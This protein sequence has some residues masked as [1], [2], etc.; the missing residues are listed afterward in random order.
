ME[1]SNLDTNKKTVLCKIMHDNQSDKGS[2]IED[3]FSNKHNY[4]ILY[5]NLFKNIK[6]NNLFIFY[7]LNNNN[8]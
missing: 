4:T 1:I 8:K 3:A 2:P 6:N 7:Y 5:D